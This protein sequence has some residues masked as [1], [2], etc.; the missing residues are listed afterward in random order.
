[1]QTVEEL[2]LALER[3][4]AENR[5]TLDLVARTILSVYPDEAE[6]NILIERLRANL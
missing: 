2:R 5:S 6:I 3:I 4:R 1:M